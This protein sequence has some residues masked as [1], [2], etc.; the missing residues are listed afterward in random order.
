MDKI[1]KLL[2]AS[3]QESKLN[4]SDR[5]SPGYCEW[6]VAEQ[7][8]LFDLLPDNFCGISLSDSFLMDPIKSVSGIIGI[9]A[10]LKQKGYQCHWCTDKN[11]LYGKIKRKK[12][13]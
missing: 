9:G 10:G 11:C 5:Y 3:L 6:S 13:A 4:I 2:E 12:M 1:Q 8:Y 7:A